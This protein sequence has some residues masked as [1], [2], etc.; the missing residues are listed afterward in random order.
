M[1]AYQYPRYHLFRRCP[2]GTPFST[3]CWM[4]LIL[5]LPAVTGCVST[6]TGRFADSLSD[7]ILNNNDL[8]T[9]ETGGPAYLLMIDGLLRED[10]GNKSLLRSA[11]D[12]YTAYAGLYVT[13]PVRK[14]KLTDKALDYAF[15]ALCAQDRDGCHLRKADF[16]AFQKTVEHMT[17][18]D[19]P[20]LYTLGTAWAGWIEAHQKDW[21]A[22]AEIS[23]VEALM[24]R[25]AALDEGYQ[26]GG[27]HLY[28]GILATLLPPALGG[29]PEIGRQHFERA[30]AL[31]Q[32]KNLMVKV[33]YARRYA[34]LVFDRELHDQLLISVIEADPDVEGYT[35]MNTLAQKDARALLDSADDYF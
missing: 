10:P 20:Y 24:T 34:R 9:V 26:D 12:L 19:V 33:V 23:R 27:A 8:E 32:G 4:M 22:V 21:N 1:H 15:Q 31:S 28:L 14:Q 7:A 29:K 30:I 6:V 11:A 13:D 16:D 5:W 25:V 35:L 18:K 17:E 3:L 2:H